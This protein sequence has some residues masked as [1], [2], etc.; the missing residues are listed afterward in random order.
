MVNLIAT[1]ILTLV[2]YNIRGNTEQIKLVE[3]RMQHIDCCLDSIL[4]HTDSIITAESAILKITEHQLIMDST[5]IKILNNREIKTWIDELAITDSIKCYGLKAEKEYFILASPIKQATGFAINFTT[6]LIIN[7][8]DQIVI[9]FKSL[10]NNPNTVY[11]QRKKLH[12][13]SFDFNDSFIHNKDYSNAYF[14]IQ[15][16]TIDKNRLLREW[17][18]NSQC[19]CNREHEHR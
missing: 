10:S 12:V 3:P 11:Y 16:S 9:E 19:K 5:Q 7:L 13:I 1:I 8:E 14:K 17:E 4:K 6:W 15:N 18:I 2:S